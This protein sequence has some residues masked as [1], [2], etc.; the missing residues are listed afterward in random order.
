MDINEKV[1]VR[2]EAYPAAE[3]TSVTTATVKTVSPVGAVSPVIVYEQMRLPDGLWLPK[4]ML[5]DSSRNKDLFD[6]IDMNNLL[7]FSGYKRSYVEVR[8]KIGS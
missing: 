5:F 8:E 4:T 2:V 1:I 3:V 7:E 6:G